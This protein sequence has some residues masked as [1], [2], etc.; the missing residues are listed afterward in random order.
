MCDRCRI[1]RESGV[2]WQAWVWQHR[3]AQYSKAEI[4]KKAGREVDRD[5]RKA[6][7]QQNGDTRLVRNEDYSGRFTSE[8][9]TMQLC[10]DIMTGW[11]P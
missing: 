8:R 4:R 1:A 3:N 7:P 5:A 6:T 10:G 9:C 2:A 11:L